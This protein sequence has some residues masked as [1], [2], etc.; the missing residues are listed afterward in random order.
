MVAATPLPELLP[1]EPRLLHAFLLLRYDMIALAEQQKLQPHQLL[2]FAHSPAI[3]THLAALKCFA[4]Q[5]FALRSLEARVKSLDILERVA[6]TSKDPIEQRKAASTILR[7][8]GLQRERPS[9]PKGEIPRT[10]G[11]GEGSS[12]STPF[13]HAPS[14]PNERFNPDSPVSVPD[15][16]RL[17]PAHFP[18]DSPPPH[19]SRDAAPSPSEAPAPSPQAP[20]GRHQT[21][22]LQTTS[23]TEPTAPTA[24]SSLPT[25]LSP[26]P[27]DRKSTR[28]NS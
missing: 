8:T 21:P 13:T 10:W 11:G 7:G 18:P 15:S 14:S 17:S 22:D 4:E 28:L 6:T 3:Q 19:P 12:V 20:K 1:H 27:P 25:P 24:L 2:A 26:R 23:P 9:S 5:A 16:R